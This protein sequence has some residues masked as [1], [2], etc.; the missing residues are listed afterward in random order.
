MDR[1][2]SKLAESS[3]RDYVVI[4]PWSGTPSRRQGPTSIARVAARLDHDV[5]IEARSG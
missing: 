5:A 3:A 4:P 2:S 1:P